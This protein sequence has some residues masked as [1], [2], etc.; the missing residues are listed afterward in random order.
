MFEIA[1][2]IKKD[3]DDRARRSL[4]PLVMERGK[5]LSRTVFFRPINITKNSKI[6]FTTNIVLNDFKQS[7]KI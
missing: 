4:S 2:R 3:L 7:K 1:E 5:L 6:K